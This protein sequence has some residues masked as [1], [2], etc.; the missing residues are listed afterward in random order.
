MQVEINGQPVDAT[1]IE[2][3]DPIADMANAYDKLT[4]SKETIDKAAAVA[5]GA[6]VLYIAY[7]AVKELTK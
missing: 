3:R 7:R 2:R 1:V 4:K 5:M 6:S